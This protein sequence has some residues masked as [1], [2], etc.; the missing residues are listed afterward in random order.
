MNAII[1]P[2]VRRYGEL[3]KESMEQCRKTLIGYRNLYAFLSQ[4]IPFYDTDLEKLYSFI[5]FLLNKLP[6]GDKGPEYHFDEEVALKFYRLQ[7]IAEDVAIRLE[8]G[9]GEGIDGPTDVGTG[10]LREKEKIKLSRLVDVLNERFGTDFK[11][12]DQLFFDSIKEDAAADTLIK[13]AALA[14]TLENFGYVFRKELEGLLIDRM[15]QNEE[16]AARFLNDAKFKEAV[17]Q[18]LLRQVYHHIRDEEPEARET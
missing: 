2:A 14:N 18:D 11:P 6:P 7:K 17:T 8:K 15:G 5:R 3:D 4:V 1:D 16:I 13:Q 10:A 9:E 12:A